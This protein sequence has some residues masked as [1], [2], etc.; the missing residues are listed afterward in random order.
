[1]TKEEMF[2]QKFSIH[3]SDIVAN[4]INLVDL[5]ELGFR[6]LRNFPDYYTIP[7][8][9]GIVSQTLVSEPGG[10]WQNAS[11]V[12]GSGR[13][14]AVTFTSKDANIS[15]HFIRFITAIQVKLEKTDT[16][17][18]SVQAILGHQILHRV[19]ISESVETGVR[20]IFAWLN[21]NYPEYSDPMS[22]W[23]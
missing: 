8:S 9:W 12:D 14:R 6:P 2:H 16:I 22:Y 20:E 15:G 4:Q 10:R 11:L 1:M 5:F 13:V 7:D 17:F 23:Y 21:K 3:I 19:A 18:S